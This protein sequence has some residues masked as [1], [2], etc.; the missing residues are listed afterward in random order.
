MDV[1][2][3]A[4]DVVTSV[5]G[6]GREVKPTHPEVI[7]GETIG[8]AW[9]TIGNRRKMVGFHGIFN[10]IEESYQVMGT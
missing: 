2:L 5:G 1:E 6:L 10:G 7:L 4:I 8:K 3:V 9:E